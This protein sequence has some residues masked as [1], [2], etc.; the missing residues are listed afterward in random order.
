M[1][2]NEE[3]VQGKILRLYFL[4]CYRPELL[5]LCNFAYSPSI[6]LFHFSCVEGQS[7]ISKG[8]SFWE[9]GLIKNIFKLLFRN[10]KKFSDPGSEGEKGVSTSGSILDVQTPFLSFYPQ[11]KC[12]PR[13]F[14]LGPSLVRTSGM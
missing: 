6:L 1:L 12:P 5:F 8:R 7:L 13:S 9:K 10:K 2:A 11:K 14:L 3:D 4:L